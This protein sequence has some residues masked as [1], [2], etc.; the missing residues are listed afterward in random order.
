MTD[1]PALFNSP[2]WESG[3]GPGYYSA[4]INVKGKVI[5]GYTWD[6][7]K[8]HDDTVVPP[9]T[10]PSAAG[11]YRI[12]FSLDGTNCPVTLN[13]FFDAYTQIVV[14]LEEAVVLEEGEEPGGGAVAHTDAVN[15]LTYIDVRILAKGGGGNSKK[16]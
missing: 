8:L 1:K 12:T 9:Y 16:K 4:E 13:T 6:V 3:D 15:N 11:D 7:N 2:V 5:Y 14:P 10:N